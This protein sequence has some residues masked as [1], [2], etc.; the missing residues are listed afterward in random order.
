[1]E[2]LEKAEPAII[3]LAILSGLGLSNLPLL[4]SN[5]GSLITLFFYV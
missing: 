1:M 4:T 2:I 5:S 3:F